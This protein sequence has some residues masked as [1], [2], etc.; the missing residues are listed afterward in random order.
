MNES[1]TP[2]VSPAHIWTLTNGFTAY[3]AVLAADELGVFRA[4][5]EGSASVDEL[6]LRCGADRGRLLALLG[7]NIA[8]GVLERDGDGFTLSAFAAAYLVPG[9]PGYLGA[10]L[11]HSPGP[12]ENWP[13]LAATVRGE[14]PVR[15]VSLDDVGF[16]A[17]LVEATFPSQ[18]A[19]ARAAVD[20]LLAGRLPAR[21]RTLD[22]GA[23]AA[24]WTIA[25]LEYLP[26]A[27]GV[28]NDLPAVLP[29]A[30]R[31]LREHGLL[32][33]V[34]MRV[35][36]YWQFDFSDDRFD[37]AILAH[38]CRA[39]GDEGAAALVAR[40]AERLVPGGVILLAEY[41]LDDDLSGPSQAQ[42]LGTTMM[43]NTERG[44]TFTRSQACTWLTEAGLEVQVVAAP[45]PP[46]T[47]V[48]A[49]RPLAEVA[50]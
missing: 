16:L 14:P 26:N 20:S 34:S 32:D 2:D 22:L 40:V 18:I 17:D 27:R 11:R 42:L 19:T 31:H 29:V 41:L 50:P 4:L 25:V 36:D 23:G 3:F 37:L 13:A 46:T 7:G 1:A 30:A 45:L 21:A 28:V 44:A 9:K 47:V 6:A 12:V 43:A 24:P 5:A 39:E 48:V 10:L 8:A 38:V 33:R 49:Q 15:D 35:G